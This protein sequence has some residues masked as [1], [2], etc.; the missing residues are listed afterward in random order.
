[1]LVFSSAGNS[2]DSG[3]NNTSM[4][5]LE[6]P[7]TAPLA[8]AAGA[9]ENSHQFTDGIRVLGSGVPSALQF[10]SSSFGDGPLPATPLTAPIIDVTKKDSTG[11]ACSALPANSLSGDFVLITRGNCNFSVKVDDAQNAGAVGVIFVDNLQEDIGVVAPSGLSGTSIPAAL[12]SA[13]DGASLRS[14]V[15]AHPG[16]KMTLGNSVVET[17][18]PAVD[19]VAFFS[20]RGPSIT[21][22]A[23]PEAMGVGT[24]VYMATQKYD[25]NGEMYDA[26]G[27]IAASGT[28]FSAPMLA[29]AAALV[30]QKN[31]G[32][33]TAQLKSAVVGTATQDLTDNGQTADETAAGNGKLN[34]GNAVSTTVTTDPA[35]VSFSGIG[36]TTPNCTG[37]ACT[38][39]VFYSGTTAATLSLTVTGTHHPTLSTPTLSFTPGSSSKPV[40]LTMTS[41]TTPG[42]Y[43]G[44]VTI[45]GGSV[46]VR[47]PYLYVVGDGVPFDLIPIA[48]QGFDNP[49][50]QSVAGGLAFKVVD[51]FGVGVQNAPV[52]FTSMNG[53]GTISSSDPN[54][55]IHGVATANAVLG[56]AGPAS[57]SARVGDLL[58]V[59][60]TGIGR[61]SP[62]INPAGIV[63]AASFQAGQGVVPGSYVSIFG[64]SLS[65]TLANAT[66]LP[67]PLAISE[68]SVSFEVPSAGISLPGSMLYADDHQVN[69][70]VPWGLQG[71][72]SVNVR[73]NV[74]LTWARPSRCRSRRMLRLSM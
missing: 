60:F 46:P 18:D 21:Y 10:I 50:G 12:I 28:S 42:L 48:G 24:S 1:M 44:A 65:D 39:T 54:T 34:G 22:L 53:G 57:F 27:Y 51:Q 68:T 52:T 32:F 26:S 58:P 67:L 38:L 31:P 23:K 20:S 13:S 11:Q 47:V 36:S 63:N 56:S 72:T 37:N 7:A 71:Q 43:E 6:S 74:F 35:T 61:S 5:T 55:D 3:Q 16:V 33:T 2:G 40:T 4:N 69:V 19:S 25:P 59:Q 62:I 70:Q 14:Y 15:S 45:Q 64:T 66:G 9:S 49:A 30:K 73:V 41:T 29:G 8:V 17:D